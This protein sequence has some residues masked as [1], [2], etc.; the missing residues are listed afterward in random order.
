MSNEITIKKE[1]ALSTVRYPSNKEFDIF[2]KLAEAT[3][4]SREFGLK[5]VG[6]GIVKAQFCWDFH[7][8]L[9]V[10]NT[11]LY[12]VQGRIAI[13]SNL[14]A[15][16]I[17]NSSNYDYEVVEHTDKI[18]TIDI[19]HKSKR[20]GEWSKIGT[21]SYGTD[22]AEREGHSGKD[23]YK[24]IPKNMYFARAITNAYKWYAPNLFSMPVNTIEE[25]GYDKDTIEGEY[26]NIEPEPVIKTTPIIPDYDYTDL[27]SLL[28]DYTMEEIADINN[29]EMPVTPV[30]I[31][32][33]AHKLWLKENEPNEQPNA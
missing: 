16:E 10:A 25:F 18:C 11:S 30:Q 19:H 6:E 22:D 20:T 27:A 32:E 12:I 9:S 8:P 29:E 28:N 23:T 24:T 2:T 17:K 33:V 3:L 31:L 26:Q 15:T 14:I 7:L 13:Q 5:T 21:V 4:E 1:A